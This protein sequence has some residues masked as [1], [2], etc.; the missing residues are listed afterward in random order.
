MLCM[1]PVGGTQLVAVILHIAVCV[2]AET[3]LGHSMS[4]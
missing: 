4:N 1:S 3:Y 2:S